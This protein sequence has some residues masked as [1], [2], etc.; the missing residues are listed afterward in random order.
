[1]TSQRMPLNIKPP[2][3]RGKNFSEVPQSAAPPVGDGVPALVDT[4]QPP[5]VSE[6]SSSTLLLDVKPD[7]MSL[8]SSR[9]SRDLCSNHDGTLLEDIKALT[10]QV[11]YGVAGVLSW[12]REFC[13]M[14]SILHV[15]EG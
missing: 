11:L 7:K 12:G 14:Q 2:E 1:M 3:L 6:G 4:D 15:S 8:P 10:F 13:V 5:S 9:T